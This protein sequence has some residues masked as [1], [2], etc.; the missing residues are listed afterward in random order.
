M[1]KIG[2]FIKRVRESQD[3]TQ[4]ELAQKLG[5]TQA[6]IAQFEKTRAALSYETIINMSPILNLNP[7]YLLSGV[8]NPFKQKGPEQIIK[9]FLFETP[10]GDI[11][12]SLVELIAKKNQKAIFL[13]LK[14]LFGGATLSGLSHEDRDIAKK[15]IARWN[16]QTR[17]G[18][19]IFALLI[20]DDDDNIFLFKR[21]DN[22]FLKESDF[23]PALKEAIENKHFEFDTVGIKYPIYRAIKDWTAINAATIDDLFKHKHYNDSLFLTRLISEVSNRQT[24]LKD[25]SAFEEI[26]A[27]FFNMSSEEI[28]VLVAYLTPKI[29]AILKKC[30]N[31]STEDKSDSS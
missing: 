29:A 23:L 24:S 6:A 17:Q 26:K 11:D 28:S 2:L 25:R 20:R 7:D 15:E 12:F 8:G 16:K 30:L 31:P 22:I 21:K 3:I 1:E 9:M 14:P 18:F 19:F 5:I 27:K 10:V 4:S 13:F